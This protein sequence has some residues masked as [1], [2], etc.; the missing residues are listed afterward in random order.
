MPRVYVWFYGRPDNSLDTKLGHPVS[1]IKLIHTVKALALQCWIQT[2]SKLTET[3]LLEPGLWLWLWLWPWPGAIGIYILAL[4]TS[5]RR[6][7]GDGPPVLDV[8]D[9]TLIWSG[10]RCCCWWWWNRDRSSDRKLESRDFGAG[11]VWY[12][13]LS[14]ILLISDE[15]QEN[16]SHCKVMAICISNPEIL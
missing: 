14:D 11:G 12:T 9:E 1:K 7:R 5:Q 4:P 13:P 6:S 16:Y 15:T 8:V 2:W 10:S 3:L